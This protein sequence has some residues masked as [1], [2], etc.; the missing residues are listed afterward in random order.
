MR[1]G[2][3]SEERHG[4][5][6]EGQGWR[7]MFVSD[8]KELRRRAR[9]H[10][11]QGPSRLAIGRP[12]NGGAGPRRGAGDRFRLKTAE[13][14]RTTCER[15]QKRVTQIREGKAWS[16]ASLTYTPSFR[17]CL[18]YSSWLFR[19]CWATLLPST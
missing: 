5:G 6:A 7:G 1:Y 13:A 16:S 19:V 9:S 4:D 17:L 15:R 11:E 18:G 10:I 2:T 14:E 3:T 8:V 12:R